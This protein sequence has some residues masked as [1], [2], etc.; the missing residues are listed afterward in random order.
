EALA[1]SR[2]FDCLQIGQHPCWDPRQWSAALKSSQKVRNRINRARREGISVR[3]A[4]PAELDAGAPLRQ[5]LDALVKRWVEAHNLP[6]MQFMATVDLFSF[7]RERRYFLAEE[8]G[9][10]AGVLMAVPIYDRHGWLLE[11]MIIEHGAAGGA[12]ESL[13]DLAMR[14]FG[15]EG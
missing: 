2:Q 13:I 7:G 6:P 12:S 8:N 3:V 14:T 5:S 9:R 1:G 11:D 10:L 4:A 15:E